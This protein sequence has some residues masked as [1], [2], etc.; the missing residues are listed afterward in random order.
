MYDIYVFTFILL[1]S[2]LVG[3][4]CSIV[5]HKCFLV[6]YITSTKRMMIKSFLLFSV[7]CFSIS[8][9]VIIIKYL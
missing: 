6:D 5:I 1:S 9:L 3:V 7:L 2:V 8:H 4:L